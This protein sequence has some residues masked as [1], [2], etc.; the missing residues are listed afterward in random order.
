MNKETLKRLHE[1][2]EGLIG[3]FSNDHPD[4]STRSKALRAL[5]EF[6]INLELDIEAIENK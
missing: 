6:R 3:F 4:E 1:V 5:V 2:C